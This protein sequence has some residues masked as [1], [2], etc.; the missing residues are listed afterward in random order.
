MK[1]QNLFSK[2][3]KKNILKMS[4]AEIFIQSAKCEV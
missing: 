3:K 4:S 2:K 1:G